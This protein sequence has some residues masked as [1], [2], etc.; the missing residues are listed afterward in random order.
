M[1]ETDPS[2]LLLWLLLQM[3][4]TFGYS[5][6]FF[7][8]ICGESWRLFLLPA[9]N[10]ILASC[11]LF[12]LLSLARPAGF[13]W[14]HLRWDNLLNLLSLVMMMLLVLLILWIKVRCL[15]HHRSWNLLIQIQ[16]IVR[17]AISARSWSSPLSSTTSTIVFESA[18][19]ST[20]SNLNHRILVTILGL[21]LLLLILWEAALLIWCAWVG[22]CMVKSV[23]C[24]GCLF[25]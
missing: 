11:M 10:P 6:N 5:R 12:T 23:V 15:L 18:T 13:S 21:L 3:L 20:T 16:I 4:S 22:D 9:W 24:C 8:M 7:I 14:L 1:V 19:Y 25:G 17:I 2:S